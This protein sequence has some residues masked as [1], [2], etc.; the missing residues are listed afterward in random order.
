M[1]KF[2]TADPTRRIPTYLQA[3]TKENLIWQL[4]LTAVL[5]VAMEA[6]NWY[7]ERKFQQKMKNFKLDV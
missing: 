3:H 1:F 5:M 6:Y 7:D 4:K 2:K